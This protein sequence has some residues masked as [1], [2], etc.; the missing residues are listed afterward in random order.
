MHLLG[1]GGAGLGPIA[2]VLLEMG[3]RISGS[4]RQRSANTDRLEEAGAQV[5]IGQVAANLTDLPIERQPDVV[6]ISSAV[7]VDN[8]ER[9]AAVE[10]GLP[11]VKRNEFLSTLLAHR[12]VIAVAGAHG[13][14]TTTAMIVKVLREG[15]IAAGYIIGANLPGYGSASA[16]RDDYFVI[17]ADEYDYMFHGL[18]PDVAV[19]TSVEWD[20]P[21]C[22]PTP[23]SF[24]QAFAQ[25]VT[26]VEPD[27]L[28]ISCAD[29]AGAE[30]LRQGWNQPRPTWLTY[31]L[32]EMAH[33]RAE[34]PQAH[35][36]SGYQAE[37]QLYNAPMG[38][39]ELR[40]PGLHNVRNALAA[41]AVGCWCGVPVADSSRILR[42]FGG[43]SRRFEM[44]GE[45]SGVTIIDDYA[46]NPTKIRAALAAARSYYP[47]RRI[48]AVVQP[49]T[50]SRTKE[51]LP[52]LVQSFGDADQVLV[53]DIFAAR[54]RDTGL[55][56]S[57]RVVAASPHPAIRHTPQLSDAVALLR[58][59]VQPGDVVITLGAG[60]SYKVG[61]MLMQELGVRA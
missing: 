47:E 7:A 19:I 28:V 32:D 37:L 34:D 5:L 57:A 31:G 10:L 11:V 18:K 33:L 55:I 44:K 17:E 15:G 54:E 22:Y 35:A 13:K 45:I 30:A 53:T 48:W 50:F 6:L 14:S 23:E 59:R 39:L 24:H 25:F 9:Q 21:D 52:Q 56:D 8:P 41:V 26:L 46:H 12:K 51:L 60:D 36:G 29:D 61:E 2:H 42:T 16:G 58:E 40:A 38:E 20:H 43:V 3:V 49:H 4:D 27:G 1:I